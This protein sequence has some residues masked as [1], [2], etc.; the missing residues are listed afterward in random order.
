MGALCPETGLI[1]DFL[2]ALCVADMP[3]RR[4]VCSALSVR[5]SFYSSSWWRNSMGIR[6]CAGMEGKMLSSPLHA[7]FTKKNRVLEMRTQAQRSP[8]LDLGPLH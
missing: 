3:L 2:P 5:F 8:A 1:K 4:P 6:L 7:V